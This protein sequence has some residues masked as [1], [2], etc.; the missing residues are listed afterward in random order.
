MGFFDRLPPEPTPE[1]EPPQPRPPRW[2]RPEAV[3]PG[4]VADELL[5][6]HSDTVAVAIIGLRGYPTGFD[7]TLCA[8]LRR[9]ERYGRLFDPG[10]LHGWQG[11]GEPPPRS[12]CA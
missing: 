10:L 1:P 8:V 5:L 6:A 12:F 7:F 11:A 9:E 3:V 2:M 4:V